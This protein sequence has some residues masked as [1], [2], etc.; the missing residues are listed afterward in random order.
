MSSRVI[1]SLVGL[2][3]LIGVLYLG[4]YVLSGAVLLLTL[5]G[6]HELFKGFRAME[7]H[8]MEKLT[9]AAT[10]SLYAGYSLKLDPVFYLFILS[11]F[12]IML[13]LI[14]LFGKTLHIYDISVTALG[15]LY[16]VLPFF[17]I[18]LVDQFDSLFFIALVFLLAWVS[19]TCAY[20]AGRFFGKRK[21]LPSVSPKKTVEG[22]I[23][24]VLGTV[25]LVTVVAAVLE[26]GFIWFAV[27]LGLFGSISGQIGDLI[28]SKIKRIMGI[29]DFG[30]LFPGHGGVLD[31]FDS[32]MMTAPIVYYVAYLYQAI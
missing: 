32:I 15:F 29:K 12:V 17:H 2:P 6:L 13:M 16:V 30:S 25:L 11:V 19:D 7:I 4:G 18:V 20:F 31:R 10:L 26:P 1:T 8:A 22:A 14:N 23:G 5:I 28:A 21:L 27:P 3:V 9:A 24:G